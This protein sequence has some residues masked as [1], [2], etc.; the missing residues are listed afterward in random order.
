MKGK[1]FFIIWVIQI[2]RGYWFGG[3][4]EI[5]IFYV[6]RYYLEY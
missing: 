5:Y 1:P 3:G 2:G 6:G 4:G